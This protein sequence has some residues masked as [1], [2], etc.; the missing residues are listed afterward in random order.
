MAFS[1]LRNVKASDFMSMLAN[2]VIIVVAIHEA[3][4]LSMQTEPMDYS[5]LIKI[6]RWCFTC[7]RKGKAKN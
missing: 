5:H 2:R 6:I 3:L 7:V 1:H 4:L